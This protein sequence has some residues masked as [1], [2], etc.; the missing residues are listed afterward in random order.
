MFGQYDFHAYCVTGFLTGGPCRTIVYDI[1]GEWKDNQTRNLLIGLVSSSMEAMTMP[2]KPTWNCY[3]GLPR[4]GC[5]VGDVVR[6]R[7]ILS[8]IAS[9]H[10]LTVCIL[11]R[12]GQ[13]A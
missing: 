8:S 9:I 4:K 12:A 13:S 11:M 1:D 10:G 6:V 3:D 5:V 2:N 7:Y